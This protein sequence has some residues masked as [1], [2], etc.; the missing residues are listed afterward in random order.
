MSLAFTLVFSFQT[1]TSKKFLGFFVT[2]DL[3]ARWVTGTGI[4]RDRKNLCIVG[5]AQVVY[6]CD[7][8]LYSYNH[9]EA[10]LHGGYRSRR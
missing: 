9:L 1:N 2:L 6:V 7:V 3:L 10:N 5:I 8:M 4:M